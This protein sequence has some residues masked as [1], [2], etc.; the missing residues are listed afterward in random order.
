MLNKVTT[1]EEEMIVDGL[2]VFE[3]NSVAGE[4]D[5]K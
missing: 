4:R 5:M 3:M 2:A 1:V